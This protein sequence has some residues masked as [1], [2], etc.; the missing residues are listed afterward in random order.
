MWTPLSRRFQSWHIDTKALPSETVTVA[1]TRVILHGVIWQCSCTA[2]RL[3][4]SAEI[5]E[6]RSFE[7][8]VVKI[9][10]K[11]QVNLCLEEQI[12]V[13]ALLSLET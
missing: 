5:V 11:Q 6:Y 2:D 1:Q 9:Q 13:R 4:C 3:G 8:A 12:A 10:K 7:S